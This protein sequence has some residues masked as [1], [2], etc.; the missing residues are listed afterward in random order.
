MISVIMTPGCSEYAVMP[1]P[2]RRTKSIFDS[3]VKL[4]GYVFPWTGG[5]CTPQFEDGFSTRVRVFGHSRWLNR[6]LE[7]ETRPKNGHSRHLLCPKLVPEWETRPRTELFQQHLD[8]KSFFNF[9]RISVGSS[10][11]LPSPPSPAPKPNPL[12]NP[13]RDADCS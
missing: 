1:V 6:L 4:S 11:L 10:S 5:S 13:S 2:A 9:L 7:W 8:L 3:T 12:A